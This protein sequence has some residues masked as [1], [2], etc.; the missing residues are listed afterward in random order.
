MIKS[1]KKHLEETNEGYFQH[2]KNAL[3]ISFNIMKGSFMGTVHSFVPALFKTGASQKIKEL[4]LFLKER[5]KI[6]SVELKFLVISF[7]GL[8]TTIHRRDI[9]CQQ[10]V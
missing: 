1:S 2:M 7:E 5:K 3:T 10:P 9:K 8:Y 4:N 6:A